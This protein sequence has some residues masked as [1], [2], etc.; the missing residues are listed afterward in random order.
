[1]EVTTLRYLEDKNFLKK[2]D[3]VTNK[4]YWIK[5][6]V[7]DS[8]ELPIRS[9]EGRVQPGSTINIDG[10]SSVRRTC[11][12]VFVAENEE[13]DLTNVD[14]LLSIKRKIRIYEGIRNDVN[15]AAYGKIIWFKLGIFVITQPTISHDA[16]GCMISLSCKD[17]MCLLNGE[18]AG[19]LPTSITF[20][21]YDQIIG[22]R[23]IN[24]DPLLLPFNELNDYTVYKY[25]DT[26]Q[27]W[28]KIKRFSTITK[29]RADELVGTRTQVP[30]FIYDIIQTL[31][32]FLSANKNTP[33][34]YLWAFSAFVLI[35]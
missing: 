20:H 7:L 14:N 24:E 26:Y 33:F 12:I 21:E 13:N 16:S 9:I 15:P 27:T 18:C 3:N 23:E 25:G 6:E 1:M 11:N 30:Q 22:I 29:D 31:G 34:Y 17:K 35:K 2:L 10:S 5:I 28:D 8:D 32:T 4:F 19:G